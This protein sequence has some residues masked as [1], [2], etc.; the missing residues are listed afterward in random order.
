MT[1]SFNIKSTKI[2]PWIRVSS[3]AIWYDHEN[4]FQVETFIFSDNPD[5]VKNRQFIHGSTIGNDGID[6]LTETAMKFHRRAVRF[7]VAQLGK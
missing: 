6:E 4:R 1:N 2:N 3:A 7:L 5:L